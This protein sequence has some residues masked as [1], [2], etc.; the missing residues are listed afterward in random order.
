[1]SFVS[2]QRERDKSVIPNVVRDFGPLSRAERH[3]LTQLRMSSFSLFT[4]DLLASE[5]RVEDG[6]SDNPIGSKPALRCSI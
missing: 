1:M 5:A 6:L 3:R 4:N 2:T